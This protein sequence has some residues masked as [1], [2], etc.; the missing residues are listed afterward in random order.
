MEFRL[1]HEWVG[2]P[3]APKVLLVLHGIM[4]N[5]RNWRSFAR[6]LVDDL[7]GWRVLTVDLR[8]HG[9]SLG[10]PPP[11]TLSTAARDLAELGVGVNAVA[12]HSFGGKVAMEYARR[13]PRGLERVLILDCPLSA[14]PEDARGTSEVAR[15]IEAVSAIPVPVERR[16]EVA[17]NLRAKGFSRS[18]AGW[19]S[20]NLKKDEVGRWTWSFD[21][22]GIRALLADYWSRDEFDLLEAPPAGVHFDLVRAV[23]SDRWSPAEVE[24]MAGLSGL[25]HV[26]RHLLADA[27]HWLHVDNPDGLLALMERVLGP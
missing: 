19:M 12:G 11:H 15:V 17:E 26:S 4:G 14:V 24:R 23:D 5:L 22:E 21:P 10:A 20:T 2:D 7:P 8:N 18:L 27:G 3:S 9:Q 6:R 16:S 25:P 1:N 13:G